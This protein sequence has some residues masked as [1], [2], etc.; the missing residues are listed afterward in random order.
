MTDST[1]ETALKALHTALAV[2]APQGARVERNALLPERVPADGLVIVRDGD[3]GQPETTMSPLR[4]HYQHRAAVDVLLA[5]E[6]GPDRDSRFDAL[7]QS[8]SAAILPD[9]TLGGAVEWSEPEAAEAQAILPAGG[10]PIKAASLTVVLHYDTS[11]PL[12]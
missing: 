3:P 1:A 9:R 11:D 2:A 5:G 7:R 4:Y 10:E 6:D 8:V 12:D